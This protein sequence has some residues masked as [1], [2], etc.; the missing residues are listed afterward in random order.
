M[1]PESSLRCSQEPASG[2]YQPDE[3]SPHL[4]TIHSNIILPPSKFSLPFTFPYQTFFCVFSPISTRLM[5]QRFITLILLIFGDADIL[6]ISSLC[7]LLH[8]PITPHSLVQIFSSAPGSQ[9]ILNLCF[10]VNV[11]NQ[12]SLSYK[13]TG[14]IILLYILIFKFL[15]KRR[16]DK[17]R[18]PDP[19]EFQIPF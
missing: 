7:S 1:E 19:S 12:N 5:F 9:N 3:S 4:P 17:T 10:P 16:E 8:P 15:E 18:G 13:T 11:E 6:W 2:L 14:K